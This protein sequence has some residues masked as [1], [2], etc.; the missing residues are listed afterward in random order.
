MYTAVAVVYVIVCLF[1]ILVVLLQAGRGGAGVA[2]GGGTSQ[3]VIR[4][5]EAGNLL[6]RVTSVCAVL[7][8]VLSA[9]LAYMS[10]STDAEVERIARDAERSAQ[11]AALSAAESAGG[12]VAGPATGAPMAGTPTAGTPTPVPTPVAP[13]EAAPIAP[14]VAIPAAEGVPEANPAP[15]VPVAVPAP[16]Q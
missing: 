16:A 9:W 8:M 6:T 5:S 3:A 10:S 11:A 15:M 12:T 4:S 7:F 14:A 1:L 13:T 2:F